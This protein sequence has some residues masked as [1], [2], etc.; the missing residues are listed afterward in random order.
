MGVVVNPI[1]GEFNFFKNATPM[2]YKKINPDYTLIIP[3]ERQMLTVGNFNL[4]GTLEI[5][6]DLVLL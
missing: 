2:S 3:I 1:T 4:L 6:G 5:I